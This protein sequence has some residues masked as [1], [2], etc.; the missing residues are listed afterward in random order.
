LDR[1]FNTDGFER[2]AARGPAAFHRRVFPQRIGNV[3][4]DGLNRMDANVQREF[5]LRELT[6]LQLRL[7]VLNVMNRSQFAAPVVDPV[8]TNFGRVTN[9]TATTMRFLLVQARIRF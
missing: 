4:A 5:P 7:D 9:H 3:R 8:S 1:W 2:S 6:S